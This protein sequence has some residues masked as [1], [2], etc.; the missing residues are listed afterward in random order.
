M[1]DL[2]Q[3]T[4][5]ENSAGAAA[6]LRSLAHIYQMKQDFPKAEQRCCA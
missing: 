5:G 6:S 4:Y 2:N 3:K 1:Y